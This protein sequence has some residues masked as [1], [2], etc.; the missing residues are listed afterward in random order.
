MPGGNQHL[1]FWGHG[2]GGGITLGL[3]VQVYHV[4]PGQLLQVAPIQQAFSKSNQQAVERQ[5]QR[6]IGKASSSW[7]NCKPL[8]KVYGSGS[9]LYWMK[10]LKIHSSL[11]E[12]VKRKL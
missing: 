2:Q 5:P 8:Q 4:Q 1:T 12:K 6:P 7:C 3:P 11:I 9:Q 10:S